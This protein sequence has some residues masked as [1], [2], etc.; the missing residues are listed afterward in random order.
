MLQPS[1]LNFLRNL[2]KNNH[3][4][5]FDKNREKYEAA[6]EDFHGLVQEVIIGLSLQDKEIAAANLQVKDCTF[7][8]NRD[9]RFSKDKSPYKSHFAASFNRDKKKMENSAGYYLHIEPSIQNFIAGGIYMPMPPRLNELRQLI[10]KEFDAWEKIVSEKGFKKSF[11]K[12]VD[13]IQTLTRPPKGFSEDDPAVEYLKMKSYL[14]EAEL[15]QDDILSKNLGK[16]ILSGFK[17]MQPMIEFLNQKVN[18]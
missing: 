13:G 3:K 17:A 15:T 16:K 11:P 14:V 18:A 7:R 9:V 5:W 12:G 2:K 1:T 6:K 8:I 10:S 4:E